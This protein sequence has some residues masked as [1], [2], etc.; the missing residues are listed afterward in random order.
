MIYS[1]EEGHTLGVNYHFWGMNDHFGGSSVQCGQILQKIL[2]EPLPP[3]LAMPG[4]WVHTAYGPP[5]NPLQEGIIL[6]LCVTTR[7]Q[8]N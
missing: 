2:A 4:F 1:G 3:F 8:F 6:K 7:A 5:I